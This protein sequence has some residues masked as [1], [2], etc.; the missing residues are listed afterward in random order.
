MVELRD[1]RADFETP[2]VEFRG[3]VTSP[4]SLREESRTNYGS[5]FG[6]Q[7]VR[8]HH[9]TPSISTVICPLT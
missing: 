4:S 2:Y 8:E 1:S 7:A 9:F 3:V 5:N 6:E